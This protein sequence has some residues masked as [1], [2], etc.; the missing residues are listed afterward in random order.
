MSRKRTLPKS[1]EQRLNECETHLYF[2]WDAR[3]LYRWQKDRYKQI[4]AELRILVADQRH[5]SRLLLSVMELCGFRYEIQPP[6]PPFHQQPI[7]LAGW[8]KDPVQQALAKEVEEAV[9]DETKMA[10][11]MA[12]QAA[13]CRSLPLS[14]F[15]EKALAV[16]WSGHD[17]SFNQL[18]CAVAQQVGSSHEDT[19]VDEP[20]VQL[21]KGMIGRDEAHIAPLVVIADLVREAG[22]HFLGF[23]EQHLG[24][25]LRFFVKGEDGRVVS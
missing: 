4:A 23:V 12:K 15:L 3:R 20:L 13:L 16:E 22:L 18:I 5:K 9:G 24:Y 10:A 19:A 21:Q 11:V 14:E 2:L 7:P 1:L 17:Y 25:R 6:G 8:R